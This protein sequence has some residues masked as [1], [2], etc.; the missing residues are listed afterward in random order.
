MDI[1][2]FI[3]IY[4]YIMAPIQEAVLQAVLTPSPGRPTGDNSKTISSITVTNPGRGYVTK[5]YIGFE[6]GGGKGAKAEPV[7]GTDGNILSVNVLNG[8]NS[9]LEVPTIHVVERNDLDIS[10]LKCT[11]G[12]YRNIQNT[13]M[14]DAITECDNDSRCKYAEYNH[15]SKTARLFDVNCT[16]NYI[17]SFSDKNNPA[18]PHTLN[19]QHNWGATD[20]KHTY[21]KDLSLKHDIN[22]LAG[23]LKLIINSNVPTITGK[24]F[25]FVEGLD[26]FLNTIDYSKISVIISSA[27]TLFNDIS[28]SHKN[29]IV[30]ILENSKNANLIFST[31]NLDAPATNRFLIIANNSPKRVCKQFAS[32]IERDHVF[33]FNSNHSEVTSWGCYAPMQLNASEERVYNQAKNIVNNLMTHIN[34]TTTHSSTAADAGSAGHQSEAIKKN[35]LMQLSNKTAL[36]FLERKVHQYDTAGQTVPDGYFGVDQNPI[37]KY[38]GPCI[39]DISATITNDDGSVTHPLN[40]ARTIFNMI[41]TTKGGKLSHCN[42][43]EVIA[44][45][46]EALATIRVS[47]IIMAFDAVRKHISPCAAY[48]IVREHYEDPD[49][50]VTQHFKNKNDKVKGKN[51]KVKTVFNELPDDML[52]E[53]GICIITGKNRHGK[54]VNKDNILMEMNIIQQKKLKKMNVEYNKLISAL[55]GN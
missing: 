3:Y 34:S 26:I 24:E 18:D 37:D 6:G 50:R 21:N 40:N 35:I 27:D 36:K 5:P 48:D 33:L 4:I 16:A 45:E 54:K 22:W 17:D 14:Y 39:A 20:N 29:N 49:V 42:K 51:I 19:S 8:G 44:R 41:H 11:D 2:I 7:M 13:T 55:N 28:A 25:P 43:P 47:L 15:D 52:K 30:K 12:F 23:E 1:N 53:V 10:K 9:Y 38:K 31:Y 32:E 46:P